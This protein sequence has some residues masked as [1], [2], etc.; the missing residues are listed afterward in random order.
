M[1]IG[2]DVLV[3]VLLC[4]DGFD[5]CVDDVVML[6]VI[7]FDLYMGVLVYVDYFLFGVVGGFM[8]GVVFDLLIELVGSCDDM[9]CVNVWFLVEIDLLFGDV[10]VWCVFWNVLVC[11]LVVVKFVKI[12][13]IKVGEMKELV[14]VVIVLLCIGIEQVQF[15]VEDGCFVVKC[16]V[17]DDIIVEV[18]VLMDGYDKLVVY[19]LWCV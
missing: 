6:I 1:L 10:Q 18:D 8:C 4:V 2:F 19:L 17:G 14:N 7:N 3:I 12:Q 15:F 5:L 9:L 11:M 13:C 16:L